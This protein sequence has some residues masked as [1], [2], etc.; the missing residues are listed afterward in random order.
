MV[1]EDKLHSA[2]SEYFGFTSFKG[3]QE[4]IIKSILNGKDTLVIMPTGGGKSLC[5]QLPAIMQEGTALIISPLIALMKN[6]VDMMR[7]YSNKDNIAHFLNSSLSRNQT[8]VVK[9]DLLSGETKMLYVAPETLTKQETIDFFKQLKISF[10]AVDEAHCISEWGHDFRPEYRRIRTMVDA[11]DD[12]VPIV[13]LTATATPKVRSDIIKNLQLKEPDQYISSFN[14]ANLYY[15]V[16]GKG[17]RENAIRQ[18][19]KFIKLNP[20]KSGIIYCLNRKTTEEIAESLCVNGI[21]AGA[22]HAGLDSATR[23]QRQDDFLMEKTHVIVATIAFGMGIDKPD[24]R[25]V[26]HFD[27]PKSLENYYQETGRAGRDGLEGKCI[28]FFSHTDMNKLEKFMRDKSVAEREIGGQHLMEVIG[29]AE[30]GHCRR[31]FLLHYFGEIYQ[32]ES[33]E[34]CDNCLNPKDTMEA[35][36]EIQL[37][38]NAI[39]CLQENFDIKYVVNFLVGKKIKQIVDFRHD[40]LPYFGKGSEKDALYWTSI[41]RHALLRNFIRKDIENYGLLKLKEQGKQYI[42]NPYPISIAIN[43]QYDGSGSAPTSTKTAAMDTV[44]FKM[45]KELRR[46]VAK[47]YKLPPFVIFQDPSLEEMT[48]YYP[49]TNEELQNITGVNK[50]KAVKYGR[51]FIELIAD[52]VEVNEIERPSDAIIKSV[53]NK[54]KN[55]IYII[56]NIDKRIPLETIARNLD[57]TMEALLD[58]IEIIIVSGTKVNIDYHINNVLDEFQQEE[59]YEYFEN[60]NQVEETDQREQSI[61]K[62]SRDYIKERSSKKIESFLEQLVHRALKELREEYDEEYTEEDIRLM[63]LKFMSD[64]AN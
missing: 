27:M 22:Y 59:V 30:I 1:V 26:I 31:R 12:S 37:A 29:Y 51:K 43:H 7:G 60:L 19:I 58:E 24:V 8:K 14:R 57:L 11:I 9:K 4:R 20:D 55:K 44:L 56:Q 52:Y 17:K 3:N 46:K 25:F 21:K 15:E 61:V 63:L 42:E 39:D 28:G 50:G 36:K 32:P 53:A 23:S 2:L 35:T 47:R 64:K 45:L 16:R 6:Q 33:C 18:I 34:N 10:V 13:A 41:L 5:Y 49:I 62:G 54:S 40:Q 38:L 48:I